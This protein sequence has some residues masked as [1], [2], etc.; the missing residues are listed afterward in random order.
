MT[1]N[2]L[3]AFNLTHELPVLLR[4]RGCVSS[5]VGAWPLAKVSPPQPASHMHSSEYVPLCSG[6]EIML[7]LGPKVVIFSLSQGCW[8]GVCD[9]NPPALQAPGQ[10]DQGAHGRCSSLGI[11]PC[12]G[13]WICVSPLSLPLCHLPP[14]ALQGR[15][16]S[17]PSPPPDTKGYCSL[18]HQIYIRLF[19]QP[20]NCAPQANSCSHQMG[21]SCSK[22]G[23]GA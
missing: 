6:V 4:D 8:P 3:P 11:G 9:H 13:V 2:N 17:A 5:W 19:P 1:V 22:E 12:S 16:T 23:T 20:A 10:K 15:M 14:G 7:L 18:P 21:E